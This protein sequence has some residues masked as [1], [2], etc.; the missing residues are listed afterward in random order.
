M[1]AWRDAWTTKGYSGKRELKETSKL[2]KQQSLADI[3]EVYQARLK[4]GGYIDFSD[5]ILEAIRLVEEHD[6]VRMS[7]AETYQ[8]VMIDEFQDTNEAQMQLIGSILSV[9][10]ESPNVFAVGDDDQSIYKFQ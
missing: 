10:E 5:M 9:S 6:V 3:Y 2:V 1:N 4:E 8:F 7:L